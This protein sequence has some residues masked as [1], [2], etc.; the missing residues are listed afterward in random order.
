M[1]DS[2]W[3]ITAL[4][5]C[6][7]RC[8]GMG[9]ALIGESAAAGLGLTLCPC[10]ISESLML[11]GLARGLGPLPWLCEAPKFGSVALYPSLSIHPGLCC[12]PRDWGWAV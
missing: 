12:W 6:H 7:H 10:C 9:P 5:T 8:P 2:W 3:R 1:A 11:R 4:L